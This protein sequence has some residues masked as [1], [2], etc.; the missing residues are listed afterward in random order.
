MFFVL[1]VDFKVE[2]NAADGSLPLSDSHNR[3]RV[4][5]SMFLLDQPNCVAPK[6]IA[7]SS[8]VNAT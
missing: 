8:L 3:A 6:S 2:R 7:S 4:G 1:L 5:R